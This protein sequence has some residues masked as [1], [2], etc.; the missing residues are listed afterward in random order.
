[1]ALRPSTGS[2]H[3][4]RA[5]SKQAQCTRML[6]SKSAPL[7]CLSFL[8]LVANGAYINLAAFEC[9]TQY[10]LRFSHFCNAGI[11]NS[12][13]NFTG[14]Y[15]LCDARAMQTCNVATSRLFW[16]ETLFSNLL[17]KSF[18]Q[19]H[20]WSRVM[21]LTDPSLNV[22][23]AE[24]CTKSF[25][26][27]VQR[28]IPIHDLWTHIP[29]AETQDVL[30]RTPLDDV[31]NWQAVPHFQSSELP[32]CQLRLWHDILVVSVLFLLHQY[33]YHS[34][35]LESSIS[36]Y[37]QFSS[38][39]SLKHASMCITA[40]SSAAGELSCLHGLVLTP[41]D[42][43]NSL[44]IIFFWASRRVTR[45]SKN[46]VYFWQA[47]LLPR[48][49][50]VIYQIF[51]VTR[52][53]VLGIVLQRT[54]FTNTSSWNSSICI[55]CEYCSWSNGLYQ[56]AWLMHWLFRKQPKRSTHAWLWA[57]DSFL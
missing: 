17:F 29:T 37:F 26:T 35:Q 33:K 46:L 52:G 20:G 8:A 16:T 56:H 53:I 18:G 50:F 15:D 42:Y 39:E 55:F 27:C 6:Y 23:A 11:I 57:Q 44:R 32:V 51:G 45:H 4:L 3:G 24:T 47:L 7:S 14:Y 25:R 40:W 22:L 34:E 10:D 43:S 19:F 2:A 12:S 30:T 38:S 28:I 31:F 9:D 41:P 54:I 21:K 5:G 13:V 48:S 49:N 36:L 1:M